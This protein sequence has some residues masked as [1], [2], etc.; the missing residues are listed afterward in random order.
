MVLDLAFFVKIIIV[1]DVNYM[2]TRNNNQLSAFILIHSFF[3]DYP[4]KADLFFYTLEITHPYYR[5]FFHPW[6]N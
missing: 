5:K 2:D 1:Y 4:I 6:S 3:I